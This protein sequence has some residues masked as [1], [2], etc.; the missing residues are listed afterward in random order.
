MEVL[1][2]IIFLLKSANIRILNLCIII[3][4]MYKEVYHVNTK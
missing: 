3:N 2:D 4:E 1:K